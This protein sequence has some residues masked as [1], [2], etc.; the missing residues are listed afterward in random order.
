MFSDGELPFLLQCRVIYLSS[1][2]HMVL[3]CICLSDDF[4]YHL[5]SA[6]TCF[7]DGAVAQVSWSRWCVVHLFHFFRKCSSVIVFRCHVYL[8]FCEM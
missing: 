7:S 3:L 5:C 6:L 4:C 8:F 2:V 1:F